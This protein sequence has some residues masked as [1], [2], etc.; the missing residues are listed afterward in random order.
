MLSLLRDGFLLGWSVAWPP[1]PINAEMIRRGLASGFWPAWSVGLGAV[2]GDFLW[3]LAVG[4]GAAR[5]TAIPGVTVVL[6]VASVVLLLALAGVFLRGAAASLRAWRAG[7]PLPAPT[8]LRS[9]RGGWLLGFTLALSSPWNL[10]F[11]L[12]VMGQQ[13]T[14]G[15]GATDALV[16]ACAVIAGALSWTVLLC[17][18]VRL[19]AR[20]ATPAWQVGT[21]ASTGV[22]MVFFAVRTIERML[23]A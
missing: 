23:S 10:A 16:T 8:A 3:A 12:A 7:E 13:A 5:L 20:F 9:A 4:F 21:Q 18:S 22:L 15:V 6:G 2:S 11:W 19:G 1:G 14:G 17:V